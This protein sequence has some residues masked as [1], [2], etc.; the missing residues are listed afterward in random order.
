MISENIYLIGFMAS[1]KSSL[2]YQLSKH[3]KMAYIDLDHEI[4]RSLNQS[5]NDI[6]K[7]KG[8]D[9]FRRQEFKALKSIYKPKI[10][11]TGGGIIC[12]PKSYQ[13]LNSETQVIWLK[14]SYKTLYQRLQSPEQQNK[15][16]LSNLDELENRFL[17]RQSL[18][19]GLATLT[20]E[21]DSQSIAQ[22][23]Q[24]ILGYLHGKH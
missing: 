5:I 15:R 1:G 6:F 7:L 3:L 10:V 23:T 24:T 4:E 11:S 18:Y 2:A 12:H 22:I 16:P 8:E 9:Y 20:V 17:E 14:A 19:E 13:F 21:T